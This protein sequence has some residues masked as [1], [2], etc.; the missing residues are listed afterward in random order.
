MTWRDLK[1]AVLIT[2]QFYRKTTWTTFLRGDVE[3]HIASTY[4]LFSLPA[5]QLIIGQFF[6]HT[7]RDRSIVFHL[8]NLIFI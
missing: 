6:F 8:I 4:L 5:A 2:L 1:Q 7:G 3:I